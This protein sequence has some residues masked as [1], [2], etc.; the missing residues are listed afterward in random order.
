MSNAQSEIAATP[1]VSVVT[2]TMAAFK[3]VRRRT[4]FEVY[5]DLRAQ[6]EQRFEWLVVCDGPEDELRETIAALNDPRVRLFG[7]PPSHVRYQLM[8][9]HYGGYHQ[10]AIG[11]RAARAALLCHVDDDD[12]IYPDYLA[13]LADTIEGEQLDFAICWIKTDFPGV[14]ELRPTPPFPIYTAQGFDVLCLM[15]RKAFVDALGGWPEHGGVIEPRGKLGDDETLLRIIV[16]RGRYRIIE[17]VLGHFRR[18][19]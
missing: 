7:S 2:A 16:E 1:R 18:V 4:L 13:R 3:P 19:R 10:K 9:I 8:G 15:I 5:E 17:E 11:V 14:P 12:R 6:K